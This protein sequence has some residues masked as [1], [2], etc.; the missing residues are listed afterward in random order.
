ME[1]TRQK[2]RPPQENRKKI[3]LVCHHTNWGN[4]EEKWKYRSHV[5]KKKTGLVSRF[6]V[7]DGGNKKSELGREKGGT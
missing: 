2:T 4:K 3:A 6:G 5:K 7:G 1:G